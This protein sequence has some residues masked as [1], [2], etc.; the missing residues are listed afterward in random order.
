MTMNPLPIY[1]T[2]LS[3]CPG[4]YRGKNRQLVYLSPSSDF[5][6]VPV[7]LAFPNLLQK[8]NNEIDIPSFLTREMKKIVARK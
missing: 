5:L 1:V 2:K 6:C 4:G 7:Q 8:L 3:Q